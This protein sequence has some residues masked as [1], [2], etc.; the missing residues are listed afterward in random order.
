MIPITVTLPTTRVVVVIEYEERLIAVNP[1][2]RVLNA[3]AQK[4]HV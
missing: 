1:G 4:A 3:L 2:F